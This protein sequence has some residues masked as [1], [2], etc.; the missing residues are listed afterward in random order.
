MTHATTSEAS[1][2]HDTD[3]DA[4]AVLAAIYVLAQDTGYELTKETAKLAEFVSQS[5]EVVY[6]EKTRASF[7][8]INCCVHPKHV[9]ATLVD[10]DGVLDVS[11]EYR[12]HSNMTRFP[13]RLHGGKTPTAYGWQVKI[14]TL[15]GL[16]GFLNSFAHLPASAA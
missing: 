2:R 6:V 13:K 10:I 15:L 12:F 3:E 14:G 4:V 16:H 1:P 9:R 7:S 5:G 8:N 11:N